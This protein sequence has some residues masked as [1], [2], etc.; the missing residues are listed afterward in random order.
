MRGA[1]A[2]LSECTDAS[3]QVKIKAEIESLKK[4]FKQAMEGVKK[5]VVKHSNSTCHYEK[6][7]TFR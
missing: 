2:Q 7:L 5:I 4:Q 1:Y 6:N 3:E